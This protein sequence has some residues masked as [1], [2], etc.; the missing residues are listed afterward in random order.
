M[1]GAEGRTWEPVAT[2]IA[3]LRR[4][5]GWA[6]SRLAELLNATSGRAGALD[7]HSI[8]RWERG[9][10]TPGPVWLPYLADVFGVD[11]TVLE[12]A[13]AVQRGV[14]ADRVDYAVTYPRR[15]D[16]AA[17]EA[18]SA[19]LAAQRRLDDAIGAEAVLPAVDGAVAVVEHLV[20]E[21]RGVIRPKV[22]DVGAQWLQFAGWL[23]TT[24]LHH[25]RAR[26]IHGQLLD[27][28]VESGN[29][30]LTAT[31]LSVQGHLAWTLDDY[32]TM[33]RKSA[34]AGRY[35]QASPA[36]RA[37]AAQQQARGHALIGEAGDAERKLDEADELAV[38]AAEDPE[39]IPPW[40]YFHST[41]LLVLQRG[42]AYKYLHAAGTPR[43]GRKA[44]DHLVAGLDGLDRDTRESEWIGWYVG[45]LA[46]LTT[47]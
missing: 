38:A 21:S 19:T 13:V 32:E 42:L 45:Q 6:Q 23:N 22:L 9:K 14:D 4:E 30:E 35:R 28:A 26:R 7:R 29:P 2:L 33:I 40:L 36:V 12:R 27:W 3:R 41:D 31:A 37:V 1:P 25:D 24:T 43:Y 34:A 15:V 5:R 47:A 16:R 8:N 17:V 18:L 20:R 11:Q 44:I 46:E 39:R 10:R